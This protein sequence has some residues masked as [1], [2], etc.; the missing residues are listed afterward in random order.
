MFIEDV[1]NVGK[2]VMYIEIIFDVMCG[3]LFFLFLYYFMYIMFMS[4]NL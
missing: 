3:F 1:V 4:C 2:C